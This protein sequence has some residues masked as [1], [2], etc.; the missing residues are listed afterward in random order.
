MF[1]VQI[2]PA[3]E[4][5]LEDIRSC[6][7]K[8]YAKYIGRMGRQPAPMLADFQ[9]QIRQGC[10]D[11]ATLDSGFAGYVVF[12]PEGDHVH[13][14][15]VAVRPDCSGLGIGRRLIRHVEHAAREEGYTAVELYTNELMTENLSM[16]PR[17]GYREVGRICQSGFNRVFFRKS[18]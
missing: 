17:L 16:Y 13:L 12:Y 6:A 5:D 18:V 1:S 15:S 8:A 14:E 2:R 11:I 9:G 4:T 10:I 3:L 7:L